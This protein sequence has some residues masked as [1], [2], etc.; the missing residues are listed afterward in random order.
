GDLPPRMRRVVELDRDG[1]QVDVAIGAIVCAQPAPDAPVFDDDFEG[2][3]AADGT[4]RATDHAQRVSALAAGSGDQIFIEAETLADQSADSIMSVGTCSHALI[5]AGAAFQ[6]EDQ[7]ALRLHQAVRKELVHGQVLHLRQA[8][9]VFFEPFPGSQLQATSNVGKAREHEREVLA[10]DTDS[11]NVIQG[12]T[13]SGARA[14]AEQG[15]LAEVPATCKVSENK[16]ASRALLGDFHK[17]DPHKVKTVGCVTLPTDH[18]SRVETEQLHAIPKVIDEVFGQGG[19]NWDAAQMRVERPS[20][21]IPLQL[22]PESLVALQDVEHVPQH[23]Q[24]DAIA[25]GSHSGRP[26]IVAHA[27]H[28]TEQIARAQLRDGMVIGKINR[29]VDRDVRPVG[30]FTAAMLHS[31]CEHALQLAEEAFDVALGAG[32]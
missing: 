15:D 30:L 2:I 16:L 17:T 4:D 6:I 24:H 32:Q 14:P 7:Q 10:G 28:L 9:A 22:T 1:M 13:G 27:R 20:A 12:R 29:R 21:I 5:A 31:R 8:Q 25:L 23:F 3:A 18:L 19:K 26:R 11:L